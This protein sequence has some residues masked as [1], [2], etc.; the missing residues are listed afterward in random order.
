MSA[1]FTPFTNA[2]VFMMSDF[3][4]IFRYVLKFTFLSSF[5]SSGARSTL[6]SR[7]FSFG[8]SSAAAGAC[9]G[10]SSSSILSSFSSK[11]SLS[12]RVWAH[13][14][15]WTSEAVARRPWAAA[16]A[17]PSWPCEPPRPPGPR[18]ASALAS[19]TKNGRSPRLPKRVPPTSSPKAARPL[20]A[21]VVELL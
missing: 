9:G 2:A 18:R 8:A 16:C 12:G 10:T 14:G 13:E 6:L 5:V 3:K 11:V 1:H 19:R 20:L 17:P 21:Y 7:V 15:A 4:N